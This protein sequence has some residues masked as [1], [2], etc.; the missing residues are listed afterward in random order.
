MLSVLSLHRSD[1]RNSAFKSLP[2]VIAPGKDPT[3][4]PFVFANG[5]RYDQTGDGTLFGRPGGGLCERQFLL[6]II[7]PNGKILKDC[8]FDELSDIIERLMELGA[9]GNLKGQEQI[10]FTAARFLL[11]LYNKLIKMQ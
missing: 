9:K 10:A 4:V 3:C 2:C 8:T 1:C 5:G 7:M 11:R 6:T